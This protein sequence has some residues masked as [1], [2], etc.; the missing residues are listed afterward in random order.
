MNYNDHNPPPIHAEYQDYEYFKSPCR[1]KNYSTP[2]LFK[3]IAG[4]PQ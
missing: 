1:R 3:N 4:H 2:N